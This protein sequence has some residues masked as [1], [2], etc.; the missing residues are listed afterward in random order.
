MWEDCLWE[1]TGMQGKYWTWWMLSTALRIGI[2]KCNETWQFGKE[3]FWGGNQIFQVASCYS[4]DKIQDEKQE[5][6]LI[7]KLKIHYF[8]YLKIKLFSI[9]VST[10]R[11]TTKTATTTK[12]HKALSC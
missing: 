9:S 5:L 1:F 8:L 6:K 2:R 3:Y 12:T 7:F 10:S 4:I 11:K